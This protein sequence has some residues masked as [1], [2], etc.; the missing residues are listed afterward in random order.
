MAFDCFSEK[1]KVIVTHGKKREVQQNG[2]E[3]D[4]RRN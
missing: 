1:K 4:V 2:Y 3:I